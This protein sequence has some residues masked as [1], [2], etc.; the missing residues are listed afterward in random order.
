MLATSWVNLL[1]PWPL[2]L[3][4]SVIFITVLGFNLLGDGL[5]TRLSPE[6]INRNSPV[7]L[8]SHRFSMW[9]EQSVSYPISCWFK[10]NRLRLVL[11]IAVV[12]ALLCG[13][14]FIN[15]WV[16]N[17]FDPSLAALSVPGGQ[18]W[19]SNRIDPYGTLFLNYTGP[20]SPQEMW[21]VQHPAGFSGSP[22]ISVDGTVYVAG[23]DG[24]V[25]A[26]NPD[27]TA[28]WKTTLPVS[29]L[30]PIAL[31]PQ[32]ILYITDSTGGLS[33]LSPEGNLIWAY[34]TD[35]L[36]KPNHG[37]IV[38]SNGTIYYLLEDVRGDSLFAVLPNGELL[39]SMQPT[40]RGANTGIRLSPDEKQIFVKNMVINAI[41]G[42]IVEL[43]L[44]TQDSAIYG[45]KA[46]LFVGADGKTCLL[47]GHVF[48]QWTQT[49][50][51]FNQVQ[52]ADWNYRG[53]GISQTSGL[54]VDAGVT[55]KGEIWIFYSGFYGGTAMYWLDPTGKILR[56]FFPVYNEN[57]RLV[58]VDGT[59]TAYICGTANISEHG[60]TTTCETYLQDG[61]EP[62]WT[63][64]FHESVQGIIGAAATSGR[65]YVITTEGLLI[66]L[67]DPGNATPVPTGTP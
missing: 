47:A 1:Q 65:I 53:A 49:S 52:C 45:N 28:P 17:R 61:T 30:G 35:A 3:T 18:T 34:S 37:P 51:G 10:A 38:A 57:T 14:Y 63:Y 55:P 60:P 25:L 8:F 7:S 9:F 6:Y 15:G 22:V 66:A 56:N 58:D 44:P 20:V 16:A 48:V 42:S 67:G 39:W 5:R 24:T 41:D 29:P 31:G 33:A 4:G 21:V 19:A 26:L 13:I 11:V 40:T 12:I 23:L 62:V 50:K 43:T 2:V 59:D 54:P 64:A 46:F 32:G 36:G 27:G